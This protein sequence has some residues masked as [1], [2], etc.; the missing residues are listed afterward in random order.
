MPNQKDC[1]KQALSLIWVT[2]TPESSRSVGNRFNLIEASLFWCFVKVVN[3]L[4]VIAHDIIRWP[5]RESVAV[6][7][8]FT[9]FA[10]VESVVGAIDGKYIPSKAP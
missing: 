10:G 1:E 7:N 2:S 9:A 8:R 4:N 5:A 6:K 3:A